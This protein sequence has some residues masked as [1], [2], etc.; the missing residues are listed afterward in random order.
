MFI[1]FKAFEIECKLFI[2]FFLKRIFIQKFKRNFMTSQNS[3]TYSLMTFPIKVVLL[4]QSTVGKT[5]LATRYVR[6]SFLNSS[7]STVGASYLTKSVQFGKDIFDFNIWD[8]AGQE[9]YR[10]LT[11]MYYRNAHFALIVFDVTNQS[12]FLEVE[13][14]IDE[15]KLNNE[16]IFII[17]CANKIDLVDKRIIEEKDGI[18]LSEKKKCKY[19]ETSAL[20]GQGIDR[21]FQMI[22]NQI[23]SDVK[24]KMS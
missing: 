11:P 12:S 7:I 14:W 6:G 9:L 5:C 22:I 21:I 2:F 17:I 10:S 1:F 20:N 24:L 3:I 19:I 23:Q 4:G 16:D 18:L 15:V 8:T 13:T